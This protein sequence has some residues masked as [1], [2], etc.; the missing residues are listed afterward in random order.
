M[1]FE[2]KHK[3]NRTAVL[4]FHGLTGSPFELKKFGK[5]LY[6]KGFDVHAASLPGHGKKFEH[7]LSTTCN[8]WTDFAYKQFEQLALEYDEVFVGGLCLGA[9]LALAVAEKYPHF[10]KGILSLSTTL[11]LDGNRMPWYSFLLPLGFS[12][13]TRF[14]YRYPEEEP[15]GIKNEK[16]RYIIK[17][18]LEK[19]SVGMDNFPMTGIY[20][21]NKL[22]KFIQKDLEKIFAPILIIHS[23]EDDLTSTKSAYKVY[24]TIS[25]N[26]KNLIILKD[27]YHM[28][29]YD[30]EKDYVFSQCTKFLDTHSKFKVKTL[31]SK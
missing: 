4:L 21:L 5:Y 19:N 6:K 30:N 1:D 25:S 24:E 9:L 15:Y 8:D 27:S 18:L 2:F 20:E 22:S 12:T 13:I 10:V 26:E 29:L 7:I 31:C 17:K 28:I 14:F 16:A 23:S 3:K 11:Y